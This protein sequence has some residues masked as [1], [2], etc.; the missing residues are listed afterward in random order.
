MTFSIEQQLFLSLLRAG[1]WHTSVDEA[2]EM[3]RNNDIDWKKFCQLMSEQTSIGIITIAMTKLPPDARPPK[4]RYF[5]IVAQSYGI[6]EANEQMNVCAAKLQKRLRAEGIESL[7][8]KG[9]G[10]AAVYEDP[11]YR[12]TGDIDLLISDQEQF[13]KANEIMTAIARFEE[14]QN[15]GQHA[16]YYIGDT[17][18]ELHGLFRLYICRKTTKHLRQWAERRQKEPSREVA[19]LTVPSAQ[20]DAVFVFAHMLNHYMTGGVGLKQMAD[21]MRLM[22]HFHCNDGALDE[23]ELLSDLRL[24]GITRH[25]RFFASLAVDILGCPP[26]C[27]PLYES[28]HKREAR[29]LLDGIF[30]TGNFG[31]RQKAQQMSTDTNRWVKKVHTAFGQLPVYWRAGRLF[32]LDA[33]YCFLKYAKTSLLEYSI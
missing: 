7:L 31:T 33:L 12:Q 5:G 25:W 30:K 32:P 17:L 16:E 28:G 19:G 9:Q 21:W 11:L 23:A 27:M 6:C 20:F 18:I 8:L 24:L 4:Q 15:S 10:L 26:E 13:N 2:A 22:Y 29:I 3:I 14:A 1:L